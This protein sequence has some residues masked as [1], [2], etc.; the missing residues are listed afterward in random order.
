MLSVFSTMKRNGSN[1]LSSAFTLIELLCVIAIIAILAALLLPALGQARLKAQ[2]I[3]CVSQLR[4]TGVAFTLFAHDHSSRFPMEVST[5]A[6]GSLEFVQPSNLA[7]ALDGSFRHFLA[8]SNEIVTPNVLV[9][10]TDTRQSAPSFPLFGPNNLSYFAA[11]NADPA[12]PESILAGDRNITNEW[13]ANNGSV[14]SNAS[15]AIRWTAELHRFKG[16]LLFSDGHVEESSDLR[17][18]AGV[19][20]R[21]NK[22]GLSFPSLKPSARIMPTGIMPS[23][24]AS[25][26]G[27]GPGGLMASGLSPSTQAAAAVAALPWPFAPAAPFIDQTVRAKASVQFTNTDSRNASLVDTSVNASNQPPVILGLSNTNS[28]PPWF[29]LLLLLLVVL[30][31][32]ILETR[33][34]LRAKKRRTLRAQL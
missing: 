22:P 20:T 29:L 31:L 28:I 3:K 2:R 6:G 33:R 1:H 26:S 30:T 24:P 8:L 34:R 4:Q 14:P 5:N 32:V 7:S 27:A 15:D 18:F 10:P 19:L 16:N 17:R 12:R 11:P 13:V 9:C 25:G 21:P 23:G